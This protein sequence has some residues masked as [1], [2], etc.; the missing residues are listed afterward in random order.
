MSSLD[1]IKKKLSIDELDKDTRSAMFNKFVEKGGQVITE[2]KSGGAIKFNRDRQ[3]A[4]NEHI[5]RKQEELKS[6]SSIL[7]EGGSSG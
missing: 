2:K 3:R 4:I 6:R 1:D 5:T 7:T